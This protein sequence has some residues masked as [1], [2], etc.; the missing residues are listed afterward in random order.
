MIPTK[1]WEV[2]AEGIGKRWLISVA[3]PAFVFWAGGIAA[4][5]LKHSFSSIETIWKSLPGIQQISIIGIAVIMV[6][7]SASL[8]E[9]FQN[10]LLRI[11]EG[12]WPH[13]LIR[14]R[15]YFA[16]RWKKKIDGKYE[17]LDTFI[18]L[19]TVSKEAAYHKLSRRD[20][21]DNEVSHLPVK[22]EHMMPTLLGN[23]L[24]A[25]E[26]YPSVRY[27]LDGVVSWPRL[28]PLLSD[29][30]REDIIAA[31]GR[32]D[33]STLRVAW[34][35]LFLVWAVW[36]WWALLSIIVALMS[37]GRMIASAGVYG[38]LIRTAYDLH[39]FDLYKKLNWPRPKL[40]GEEI[41]FGESLTEYLFR[42]PLTHS[43]AFDFD[44]EIK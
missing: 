29:T 34:S 32:L 42:G 2:V 5:M 13:R 10:R 31:R 44:Q 19:D 41:E 17:E 23:L 1:M 27:G 18:E 12:Y 22:E 3:G 37:Y 11:I 4:Y 39:R 16:N 9:H 26:M 35:F 8:V 7:F 25:A 21:L 14:V 43:A 36:Q 24:K 40:I 30:V 6:L 20:F 15:Y 38:E 33:E 28:Y